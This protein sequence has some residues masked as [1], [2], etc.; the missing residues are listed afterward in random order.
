MGGETCVASISE[1]VVARLAG[2]Y[3]ARSARTKKVVDVLS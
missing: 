3:R 1:L 2:P